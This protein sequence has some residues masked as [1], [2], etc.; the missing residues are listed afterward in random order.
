[1]EEK[2]KFCLMLINQ[3][4]DK[5]KELEIVYRHKNDL[6]NY[7]MGR[8]QALDKSA[9]LIT[10]ILNSENPNSVSNQPTEE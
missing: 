5:A 8:R 4:L 7:W 6:H 2:V 10:Y 3:E 1:M 9:Q